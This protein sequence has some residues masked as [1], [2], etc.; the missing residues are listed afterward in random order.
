MDRV[1]DLRP[2]LVSFNGASFDLP[3][4]RY[5]AMMNRVAAP[6]LECRNDFHRY[7]ESHVDLCDVLS[8]Y[9]S[10]GKLKLDALCCALGLPGKPDG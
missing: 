10:P 4:L 8:C 6:G 7:S 9:S 2:C 5:R 1:N 3:V